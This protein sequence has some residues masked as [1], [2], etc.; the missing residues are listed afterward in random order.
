VLATSRAPLRIRGEQI[1]PVPP[2]A[3]PTIAVD[4]G[5]LAQTDAVALFVQRARAADPSFA[6]TESNAAT[7]AE[8]CRRLDG[9]PLAIELA[10]ARLRLLSPD[11]LLVRLTER[12]HLLSGGERDLPDRHRALR[13]TIA[14]S[15]D[16]LSADQQAL[17]RRLSVFV[18]GFTLDATE[19]VSR[20]N[21][22]TM[23]VAVLDGLGVLVD[24]SLVTR[25]VSASGDV[26]YGML[27]TIREFGLEQLMASGEEA[28]IRD[29]HAAWCIEIAERSWHIWFGT[30]QVDDWLPHLALDHDNLRSALDW[31]AADTDPTRLVRLT[32]ALTAFW[33]QGGGRRE[34]R[35]WFDRALDRKPRVTG[36]LRARALN[37]ASLLARNQED[38][39]RAAAFAR[40]CLANCEEGDDWLVGAAWWLLGG[41]SRGMG[42]YESSVAEL[43]RAIEL[44]RL[45]G[46]QWCVESIQIDLGAASLGVG[47]YDRAA[48]LFDDALLRSR[49]RDDRFDTVYALGY[50]GLTA[51]AMRDAAMAT[52]RYAEAIPLWRTLQAPE[53]V[54]EG[55]AGAATVAALLG[56][57]ERSANL[58]GAADALRERAG[59][60]FTL[61]E[62]E[63]FERAQRSVRER[64]GECAYA[65]AY[66]AGRQ[67]TVDQ[68]I[69]EAASGEPA[70]VVS[71]RADADPYGLTPRE[72]EVLAL[73][74]RRL[75]D[76]EIAEAL[77]ISPQTA[78]THVKR[79]L[80]KLGVTN[81]REA[82]AIAARDLPV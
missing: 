49:A 39:E 19:A 60:A 17:F 18:G 69:A 10:A 67:L 61:P 70:P 53:L 46:P 72:R 24:E 55:L 79:V 38:F 64:L 30:S 48:A 62:R 71:V 23:A 68:A 57:P 9:L 80:G 82:A 73:L 22:T 33:H 1:L 44:Y 25:T 59:H 4:A 51:C 75:T 28:A 32:G 21:S 7:I 14:W 47:D 29:A 13:D 74:S 43:N 52:S 41:I 65:A 63:L 66:D 76:P 27:E 56:S 3:L 50:L 45:Q 78:S 8:I 11:A 35:M 20:Q 81:R 16:L 2:L 54:A 34:G 37:G 15:Y 40:E 6:L 31:F 26:R 36:S 42:A 77:F 12:L 5:Q 58:Y